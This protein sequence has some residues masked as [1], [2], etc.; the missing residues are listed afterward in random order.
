MG[1]T[2]SSH[3]DPDA[4]ADASPM[5][6]TLPASIP[7]SKLLEQEPEILFCRAA[8][9]PL[10]PQPSNAG[11]PRVPII[12]VWDPCHIISPP[13]LLSASTNSHNS[14]IANQNSIEVVLISHGESE[15]A[16][17][18]DLISGRSPE[19]PLTARGERQ[20]RALAVFLK[21]R[22][23][24]FESVYSSP[25]DR[26]RAT[27]SLV[28]RVILCDQLHVHFCI[29]GTLHKFGYLSSNFIILVIISSKNCPS[30]LGNRNW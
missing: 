22:G 23:V 8:A 26:A 27:A 21:S 1:S 3:S 19:A 4:D 9:S 11:T 6:I 20:A 29:N 13:P 15:V 2:V 7:P 24:R 25:L 30:L 12:R 18:P 5:P 10:S 28:S 14:I 17:R 16:L